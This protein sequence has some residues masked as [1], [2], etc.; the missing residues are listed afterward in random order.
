MASSGVHIRTVRCFQIVRL[1]QIHVIAKH[2][3][4]KAYLMQAHVFESMLKEKQIV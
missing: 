1:F 2:M 4:S 3:V